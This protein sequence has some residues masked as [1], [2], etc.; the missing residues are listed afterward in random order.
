MK[1]PD[2]RHEAQVEIA[3]DRQLLKQIQSVLDE[4]DA[5]ADNDAEAEDVEADDEWKDL[6]SK[7]MAEAVPAQAQSRV[8]VD[9]KQ[10]KEIKEPKV[11]TFPTTTTSPPAPAA[12]TPPSTL[13]NRHNQETPQDTAKA[14]G[15]KH[16]AEQTRVQ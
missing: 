2:R 13:R 15:R 11:T 10:D 16:L 8:Q 12:T 9:Q 4:E 6:F 1:Q 14:T 7:P 3:R 5:R